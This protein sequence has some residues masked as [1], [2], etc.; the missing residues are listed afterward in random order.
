MQTNNRNNRNR[1][2]QEMETT[3]ITLLCCLKR[4][5]LFPKDIHRLLEDALLMLYGIF[6]TYQGTRYFVS[7]NV[8]KRF[9]FQK[10]LSEFEKNSQNL[11]DNDGVF[12][13]ANAYF[14]MEVLMRPNGKDYSTFGHRTPGFPCEYEEKFFESLSFRDLLSFNM[15]VLASKL[16]YSAC[17]CSVEFAKRMQGKTRS[18]I[19]KLFDI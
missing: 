11:S 9:G 13:S 4:Q 14:E 6:V 7:N 12:S 18:E 8:E 5:N 2:F 19:E 17:L 16:Q 10:L 15:F 1:W 3:R